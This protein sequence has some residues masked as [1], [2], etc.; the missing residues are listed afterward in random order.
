MFYSL[1]RLAS[2]AS[3]DKWNFFP[4]FLIPYLTGLDTPKEPI[5]NL[6][7]RRRDTVLL[8]L[9]HVHILG[10]IN[11]GQMDGILNKIADDV[12][13]IMDG[14]TVVVGAWKC[15]VACVMWTEIDWSMYQLKLS[16]W[17]SHRIRLWTESHLSHSST[18]VAILY[19]CP[20]KLCICVVYKEKKYW[21][22]YIF[23]SQSRNQ[24][25][26]S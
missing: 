25:M 17:K 26:H 19:Y 8:R 2:S 12:S 20:R 13:T 24:M 7:S 5:I 15:N 23:L 21:L 10:P 22:I 9:R 16:L 1:W 6:I 18:S 11:H 14:V 4:T 3:H